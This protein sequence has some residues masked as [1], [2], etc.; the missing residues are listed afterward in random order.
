MHS[1]PLIILLGGLALVLVLLACSVESPFTPVIPPVNT[2]GAGSTDT[3]TPVLIIPTLQATPTPTIPAATDTPLPISPTA[4]ATVTALPLFKSPPI[5]FLDMLDDNYG[6]ALTNEAVVRTDDGGATWYNVK[7]AGLGAAPAS[8]FFLDK[9]NA[10]VTLMG[11]DPTSGTLYRTTD[12]GLTWSSA[13]VPFGG[14]SLHFVDSMHGWELIGL[15]AGMSHES[16]AI[17]LT[18][19]GGGTW[20]RVFINEPA[21]SGSSDSL[22]LAGDKNGITALDPDHAWVTGAQPSSDFI[23]VYS[24]Q[25]GGTTWAHQD[26]TIPSSYSGALTNASLPVFFGGNEGVLPVLLFAATNGA[27]FYVSHDG[28]RTW[29]PTTPIGQGGYLAIPSPK[30]FFVWDGSAPLNVS[31]DA[32]LSWSTLNPNINIQGNMIS[33]QF[34][35]AVT[36]YALTSDTS[37][38]HELYRTLDGGL[39]WNVL[40]P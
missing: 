24:S 7:P 25:D 13:A 30:D 11:S 16:V 34:V 5:E 19:D 39:T 3:P 33:L 21:V 10:W 15:N 22:P 6:W 8:S 31:H 29:T 26:L 9:D 17:F 2:A 23:Y 37:S 20:S 18:A 40:I 4:T 32:G 14:G 28:G 35:D 38:H 12:A 27:D 1:R 36:G